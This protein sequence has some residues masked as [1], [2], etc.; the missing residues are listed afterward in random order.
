VNHPLCGNHEGDVIRLYTSKTNSAVNSG[1]RQ[2]AVTCASGR[3][4]V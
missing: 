1:I 2:Q 4:R 3:Y